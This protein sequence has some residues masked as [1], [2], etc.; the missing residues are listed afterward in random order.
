MP[1]TGHAGHW[2]PQCRLH[3]NPEGEFAA[4]ALKLMH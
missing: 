1:G 3:R 4:D 2:T